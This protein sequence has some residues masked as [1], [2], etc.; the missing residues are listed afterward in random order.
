[1]TVASISGIRGIFN[2]DLLPADICRYAENF[3]SLTTARDAL[4]GRDT[5][6]TGSLISRLASGA[7]LGAGMRVVDYGV[8]ST[9]ALFRESRT[10]RAAALM[11]TASHN[12]PEWNG[13][14]FILDGRGIVQGELD[15][16]LTHKRGRISQFGA[17]R[18]TRQQRSSYNSELVAAAGESSCEGI[19][20][21]LDING[22]AAVGHAPTILEDLG[23][24]L[25]I[26][27]GAPGLFSR[28][29]DPTNDPLELLTATVKEKR[30]H[31]GLAFDCDGDRLVVVDHE[32]RK[33][34]GDYMLT[35]AFMEMLPTLPNRSVVV[36]ADT[37]MAV[38]DVVSGLGGT[39]YRSRVG[40]ANVISEMLKRGV[41]LGGEGSSGG[42]I[43]GDFN[44]CRD[45]MTAA[46]TI[47]K[48][49]KKK[50]A[51]ILSLVP[52]YNIA[53]VKLTIDRKKALAAIK[54]LR[55]EYPESDELDGIKIQQ[56]P[57]SWV[58]IRPSGT[59]DAVRISAEATSAKD[60]QELADS[61][62]TKVKRLAA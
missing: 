17:G 28:T 33:R 61:F 39:V 12:E 40:E 24:K 42:L 23:C 9:P 54:K 35:L 59:E 48:A 55:K 31:V 58:L 29:V 43:D 62:M 49:I 27:G 1:M 45:S 32:G 15:K 25:T 38:D 5:R 19:E 47:V 50:G 37:T 3:A 52:S 60:A 7:L 8:I 20:V 10:K 36:S 6:S 16:V 53:R 30:A 13:L 44:Y 34:T 11:V 14:K 2:Q 51:R 41:R 56:S 26:L 4:I 46:I 21:V 57:R 22:G 18:L